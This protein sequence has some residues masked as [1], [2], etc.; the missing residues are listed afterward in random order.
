M[1]L[2]LER[3]PFLFTAS[4]IAVPLLLQAC[5]ARDEAPSVDPHL[6]GASILHLERLL[7][8]RL[9]VYALNS[10]NGVSVAYRAQETFPLDPEPAMETMQ[11]ALTAPTGK[12]IERSRKPGSRAPRAMVEDLLQ[13]ATGVPGGG[14]FI[15]AQ[16]LQA[17]KQEK[18][19]VLAPVIPKDWP[20][21]EHTLVQKGDACFLALVWPANGSPVGLAV[22]T[23]SPAKKSRSDI[24]A[25]AAR[26]SFRM[27]GL[28]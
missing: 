14:R 21:W 17:L 2:L 25:A 12:Q 15:G 22:C 20:W 26:Q 23:E 3:R 27:L 13:M 16:Q 28:A 1:S 6:E 19:S 5:A 11:S 18:K 7:E 4:A 24:L 9:G 8:G 10:R